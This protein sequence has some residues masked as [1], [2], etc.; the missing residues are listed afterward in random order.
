MDTHTHTT[1]MKRGVEQVMDTL[2]V[3]ADRLPV[4]RWYDADHHNTTAFKVG[5]NAHTYVSLIFSL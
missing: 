5:R 4:P 3:L 2:I 1:R